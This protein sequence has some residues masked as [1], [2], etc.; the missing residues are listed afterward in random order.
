MLQITRFSIVILIFT[1][2]LGSCQFNTVYD[3]FYVIEDN[4]WYKDNA[5][6][7]NVEIKDTASLYNF[8]LV[9]NNTTDYRFSNLFVFM[10]TTFPNSNMTRDTIEFVLANASGK[11]LG[12]GWGNVKESDILL[13]SGLKFPLSGPYEFFI[14]QAM[15]NDTL[16]GIRS[17]GIR[18]EKTE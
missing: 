3:E 9:L 18:I 2:F 7:F 14:Q 6:H 16:T 4:K 13:K 17:V 1:L 5:V 11:W 8:H 15:R 10:T 12:K